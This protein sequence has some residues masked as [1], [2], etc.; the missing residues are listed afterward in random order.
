MSGKRESLRKAESLRKE[1][2]LR[3]QEEEEYRAVKSRDVS[4]SL[5]W[6]VVGLEEYSDGYYFR[7]QYT[8]DCIVSIHRVICRGSLWSEMLYQ[9]RRA[10]SSVAINQHVCGR[11]RQ[12]PP[13]WPLKDVVNT[14]SER[15]V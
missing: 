9:S 3:K 13:L 10:H 11:P 1:E 7:Q 2:S 12:I 6:R 14:A 4:S 8:N 15:V 5:H